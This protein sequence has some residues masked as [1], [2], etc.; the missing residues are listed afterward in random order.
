MQK[1]SF[2]SG[3]TKIAAIIEIPD[4]HEKEVP[5]VIFC[6]GYT[7]YRDEFG[8]FP[9]ISEVLC[10]NGI[11]TFRFDFRGC[12]ESTGN[13][14]RGRMLC[15][16]EWIE[17]IYNAYQY[18]KTMSWVDKDSIILLGVSMGGAAVLSS[19]KILKGIKKAIAV[20]PVNNGHEWMK[21]LWLKHSGE[22]GWR[23]FLTNLDEKMKNRV[24]SGVDESIGVNEVLA[25]SQEDY[26]VFINNTKQYPLST[27]YAT[28]SSAEE[29]IYRVN[30]TRELL[31]SAHPI[32][33][34]FIHGTGDTLVPYKDTE[35]M[36]QAYLFKKKL[37]L[38]KNK[39]HG[40]LLDNNIRALIEELLQWIKTDY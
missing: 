21:G 37:I 13:Y 7:S 15:G 1:A 24:M 17:D 6:H 4:T 19:L 10:K 25:F 5:C 35:S 22:N 20:A 26:D 39:T 32:P 3:T 31:S 27:A 38:L 30:T 11:G 12:G 40:L 23:K 16:T 29:I 28:W 2:F 18:V 33:V 14:S 9:R 8:A 34:L 36:H